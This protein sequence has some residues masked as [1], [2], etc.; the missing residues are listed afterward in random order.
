M[1]HIDFRWRLIDPLGGFESGFKTLCDT[2]Y[3]IRMEYTHRDHVEDDT[4]G[5]KIE[6][7]SIGAHKSFGVPTKK[8]GRQMLEIFV[9]MQKLEFGENMQMLE[10]YRA[11]SKN[12]S[13]TMVLEWTKCPKR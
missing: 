12:V 13:K 11:Q 1:W 7:S 2:F 9:N 8:I 4:V 3:I 6:I 10:I 5:Q